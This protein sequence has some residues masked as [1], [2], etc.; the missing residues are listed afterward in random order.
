MAAASFLATSSSISSLEL[1]STVFV[2]ALNSEISLQNIPSNAITVI[3]RYVFPTANNIS[4][5][6]IIIIIIIN[7]TSNNT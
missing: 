7:I 6:I 3:Q 5:I 1:H 4:T 2:T